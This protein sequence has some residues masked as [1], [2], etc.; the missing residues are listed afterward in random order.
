MRGA[1]DVRSA[2]PSLRITLQ[3][4]AIALGYVDG[5]LDGMYP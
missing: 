1:T 5:L 3:L 4:I 2:P